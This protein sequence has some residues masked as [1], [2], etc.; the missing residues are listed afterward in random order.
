MPYADDHLTTIKGLKAVSQS[1]YSAENFLKNRIQ[2]LETRQD[3]NV[4][5]AT[6]DSE[7]IDARIDSWGNQHSSAGSAVRNG[8]IHLEEK[9]DM[10]CVSLQ[11]QIQDIAEAVLGMSVMLVEV[12]QALR[13]LKEE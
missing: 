6:E 1:I 9:F 2:T 3:A 4:T 7:V 5:E 12:K 13:D 8:Q 10:L 11:T